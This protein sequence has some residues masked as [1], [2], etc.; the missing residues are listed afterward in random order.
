MPDLTAAFADRLR[1]L[2]VFFAR[3]AAAQSASHGARSKQELLA[4]DVLGVRGPT[5][6]GDLADHLGVGRSAVTPLV[7][8]L[9]DEG[10][11]ERRRSEAD[12]RVWHVALTAKGRGVFDAASA[13]YEQVA[14]AM[15]AQLSPADGARLVDLLA[16]VADG[17]D[18]GGD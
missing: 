9:A 11:V 15:L 3:V 14:A 1:Q 17:A 18:G 13:A 10:I 4:V 12:R 5:R 8:R 2:G 7:D 6:M 16:C